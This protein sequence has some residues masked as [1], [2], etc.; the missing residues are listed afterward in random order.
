MPSR[1]STKKKNENLHPAT[2]RLGPVIAM[3]LPVLTAAYRHDEFL[4]IPDI[5]R[6]ID[7]PTTGV[8]RAAARLAKAYVPDP[9][10]TSERRHVPLLEVRDHETLTWS[11]ADKVERPV[12][13]LQLTP[14]GYS[15]AIEAIESYPQGKAARQT[16]FQ[17]LMVPAG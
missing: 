15:W 14:A 17:R 10:A 11:G 4:S 7:V 5:E 3:M 6:R 8:R 2:Y 9:T 12:A 1:A 13:L 16:V